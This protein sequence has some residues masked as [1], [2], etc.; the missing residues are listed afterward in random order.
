MNITLKPAMKRALPLAIAAMSLL[1]LAAN[2]TKNETKVQKPIVPEYLQADKYEKKGNERIKAGLTQEKAY[3]DEA[4]KAKFDKANLNDDYKI[5]K[6]E[7][8]IY[9]WGGKVHGV[10][11]GYIYPN[12]LVLNGCDAKA[13]V[14]RRHPEYVLYPTQNFSSVKYP[15]QKEWFKKMDKNNDQA[16]SPTEVLRGRY[17]IELEKVG[18]EVNCANGKIREAE[19]YID[20]RSS[21]ND[22]KGRAAFASF[23]IFAGVVAALGGGAG[24]YAGDRRE[25]AFGCL[26]MLAGLAA[27]GIGYGLISKSDIKDYKNRW[28][29][30]IEAANIEKNAA[31]EKQ[32]KIKQDINFLDAQLEYEYSKMHK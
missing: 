13:V 10:L 11:Y 30:K 7:A 27:A 4:T 14:N 2:T 16:L 15:Q 5:S 31:L 12:G 26:T 25:N 23:W 29:S 6:E 3:K 28:D 18:H 1:P 22:I 21:I 32:E 8:A 24:G 9:N 17:L 19:H 20:N